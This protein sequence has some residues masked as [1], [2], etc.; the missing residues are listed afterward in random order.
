MDHYRAGK[1]LAQN[2]SDCFRYISR[3]CTTEWMQVKISSFVNGYL[4][5]EPT[6][7]FQTTAVSSVIVGHALRRSMETRALG[8]RTCDVFR[9]DAGGVV[10]N[11]AYRD[12]LRRTGSLLAEK[13]VIRWSKCW[14]W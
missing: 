3:D 12:S 6:E 13:W 14:T 7:V 11:I 1:R 5:W 4:H 8:Y 9:Y 2:R 10:H